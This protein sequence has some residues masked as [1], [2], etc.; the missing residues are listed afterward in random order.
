MPTGANKTSFTP[1]DLLSMTDGP[2]YELVG[3]QLVERP[4]SA[5]SSSVAT[6][7]I[8]MLSEFVRRNRLGIVFAPDRGYQCFPAD[9]AMVRKPDL[10]FVRRGRFA[11]ELPEGHIRFAPDLAVEILSPNE[12]AYDVDEKAEQYLAAGVRLVWVMNPVVR[13]VRVQQPGAP[14]VLLR[15]QDALDGGEALPGFS[16][17]IRKIFARVEAALAE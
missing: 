17:P 15:E 10:S 7:L 13:T 12:L 2:V 9:P 14:G 5:L 6:I 16:C 1:D 4:V 3:G 11:G 8:G